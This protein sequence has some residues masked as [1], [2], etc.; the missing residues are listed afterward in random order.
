MIEFDRKYRIRLE[1]ESV[2]KIV[3]DGKC[4]EEVNEFKGV[5]SK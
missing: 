1:N 4:L 5:V 2:C 3:L